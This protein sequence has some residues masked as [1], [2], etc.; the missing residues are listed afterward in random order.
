VYISVIDQIK[1]WSSIIQAY[2]EIPF[3]RE[4]DKMVS[5]Y[6]E[7]FFEEYKILEDGADKEPFDLE[8][9]VLIDK[10]LESS[11]LFLEQY[12]QE[13]EDVDL[14][15]AKNEAQQ[16]KKNLTNL[17][18]NQV[19]KGLAKFWAKCRKKGLPILKEVFFELAKEIVKEL[20]KKMIGL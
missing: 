10:Y 16:L 8:K 9:Q 5:K 14:T 7:E 15:D 3:F 1:Q 2:N 11:I 19:V 4:D 6:T 12:E 13:N 17:S 20:G 18:K